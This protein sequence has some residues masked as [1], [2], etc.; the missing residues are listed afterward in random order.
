MFIADTLS[1][2]Y[3][4]TDGE[5]LDLNDDIEVMVHS[6][7]TN[8]PATS[9]KIAEIKA[10]TKEDETLQTLKE[11]IKQGWPKH[12]QSVPTCITPY[13]NV[14]YELSEAEGLLFK[15]NRL[16]IPLSTRKDML[17]LIH[18]SHQG[19]E[20]CKNRA[21]SV[22]YWPG[23]NNDIITVVSNCTVCATFRSQNQ[24]EPMIPHEIPELP[25][26]KVASD[27]CEYQGETYLVIVDYFSKYIE[28]SLLPNKTAKTVITHT[29]S[30]FARHGIPQEL[31]SDNMPF[32]SR[33]FRVFAEN[34]GLK[35]TISSPTYPQSNGLSEKA[36][37]TVKRIL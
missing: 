8:I 29:K 30:I 25:W 12:R 23:M 14:R 18:E 36:V 15:D 2:A 7:V 33:E 37:Q 24:K 13:W 19:I 28:V 11:T 10:A 34:W 17:Q 5:Q 4:K 22:I 26:Q 16:I 6:L 35:V 32:N 27:L 31:I 9:E 21:R 3:L 20:K 1:R